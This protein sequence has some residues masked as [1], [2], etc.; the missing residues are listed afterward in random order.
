MKKIKLRTL[1]ISIA[2]ILSTYFSQ[3]TLAYYTVGG[4]ATN[5]VTSGGVKLQ[6]HEETADGTAFPEKGVYVEPGDVVSKRVSV[7]N[8]ST[9]PFYLRVILISGV[10]KSSLSGDDA[11]D[12]DLNTTD[13][14]LH[15]DGYIYYNS[16]L[17]PGERT[18]PVF[19]EVGI[20]GRD[21]FRGE[22]LTLTVTAHATQ[23]KNNPAEHPWDAAGWPEN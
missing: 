7:E 5:V 22:T 2:L 19:T 3:E 20:A 21:V 10:E 11:F 4:V 15:E 1:V 8:I 23:S 13:W 18:T 14:T 9:Q 12:I 6:I 17:Q 16:I